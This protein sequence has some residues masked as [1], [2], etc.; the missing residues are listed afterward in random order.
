MTAF[1]RSS[2]SFQELAYTVEIRTANSRFLDV[3]VRTPWALP[4]LERQALSRIRDTIL[5]GRVEVNI[6]VAPAMESASASG[7]AHVVR[8]FKAVKSALE[9]IASELKME[10]KLELPHLITAYNL[11][12]HELPEGMDGDQLA[13]SVLPALDQ[14][15]DALVSMREK[16]GEA[17]NRTL[18][19]S[20]DAVSVLT[21]SISSLAAAV[22]QSVKKKV[23]ERISSLTA[24]KA[25]VDPVR[26]AQEVAILADKADVTEELARIQSHIDQVRATRSAEPPQGRKLEFLLQEIQ[27]EVNTVGSKT[28][29][30]RIA[31]AVVNLKT[32]LEKMR[33]IA[34]NVE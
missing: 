6:R 34:Q 24:E 32:E 28:P 10:A 23:E 29:D 19:E 11:L 5:R 15:L 8:R 22:P 2:F 1:G 7:A 25:P 26:L 17:M 33:E 20:L 13:K 18:A 9:D 14:A 3:R 30:V 12:A 21:D 27:R 31:R 16:E 4:E